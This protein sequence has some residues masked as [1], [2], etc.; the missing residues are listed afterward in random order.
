MKTITVFITTA[1]TILLFINCSRRQGNFFQPGNEDKFIA[2]QPFDNYDPVKIDFICNEIQNFF[3]AHVVVL[4]P[5]SIPETFRLP[6][7]M[8]YSADS[9]LNLLSTK[10]DSKVI[11][12]IGVTSWGIGI[13]QKGKLK[14]SHPFHYYPVQRIFGLAD[15]GGNCAVISD[16]YFKSG[17]PTVFQHRLRTTLIHEIG[18][19]IG[20]DHCSSEKCIMSE[21]NGTVYGLDKSE[22]DYC[23]QCRKK[24]EQINPVYPW[25]KPAV[26]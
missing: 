16:A 1:L 23:V 6:L 20:L 13:T 21:Q 12:V 18:H 9:I 11:E 19:T 26:H 14:T 22:D 25:L 24:L 2:I 7:S 3:N 8:S 15:F 10:L 5:I 17:D 4:P